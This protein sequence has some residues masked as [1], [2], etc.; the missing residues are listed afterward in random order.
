MI[1]NSLLSLA[2]FHDVYSCEGQQQIYYLQRVKMESN[3][4][5]ASYV[6][7]RCSNLSLS[8]H[9]CI[10]LANF[11]AKLISLDLW[12]CMSTA[13]LV[14][15]FSIIRQSNFWACSIFMKSRSSHCIWITTSKSRAFTAVGNNPKFLY[16]IFEMQG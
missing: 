1:K 12:K 7:L 11:N 13:I 6:Y 16:P 8:L 5:I 10:T 14:V 15:A 2:G 9:I 4:P 3:L